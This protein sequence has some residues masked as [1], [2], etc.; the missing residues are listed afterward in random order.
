VSVSLTLP[1]SG[2]TITAALHSSNYTAIQNAINN[3]TVPKPTSIA[4]GEV[5]VWDGAAWVRSTT[6]RI[7]ATSLGSGTPGATNFLRGDGAWTNAVK[8]T[9]GTLAAGPP[10]SPVTND[11]WLATD[12][13][14]NGTCWQF[15]YN[16]A[17]ATYKWEFIGRGFYGCH[18]REHHRFRFQHEL[19]EPLRTLDHERESGGL[20]GAPQRLPVEHRRQHPQCQHRR[21]GWRCEPKRPRSGRDHYREPSGYQPSGSTNRRSSFDRH[22]APLSA[23]VRY[24]AYQYQQRD[25]RSRPHSDHLTETGSFTQLS[26]QGL[27]QFSGRGSLPLASS[28]AWPIFSTTQ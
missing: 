15:R 20:S 2:Q 25:A 17:E 6:T 16:S 12:V 27:A 13:D 9:V 10:G 21:R 8:T 22:P 7:G 5:P 1:V 28:P 24:D 4:S 23:V 19:P 18:Q 26:T 11:I 14:A 3:D